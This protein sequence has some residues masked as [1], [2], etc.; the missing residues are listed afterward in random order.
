MTAILY[1][2]HPLEAVLWIEGHKEEGNLTK[3][4]HSLLLI[5][6]KW[7]GYWAMFEDKTTY[8]LTLANS[9][10]PLPSLHYCKCCC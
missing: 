8:L 3:R 4:C 9:I 2:K 7:E 10:E 5:S 1:D 6:E